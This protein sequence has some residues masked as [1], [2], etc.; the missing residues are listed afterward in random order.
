MKETTM[1][2]AYLLYD[3]FTAL[4][5]IGPHDVLN[6]VPGN[7][8]IFVAEKPGRIRN[9]SDTLSLVADASL[10]EVQSPDI[11]VVPGGFGNRT[12]LEHEPLHE[13]IRTV[14]ETSTW[15]TSVCT[16][17]LLLA[18]SGLLDG[19]PATTHWL[20]RDLLAELGAKPVPERVV[21]HGKIVTAAGVSSG[22]DMALRLVQQINGDEVAQAVQL[23]IEYDPAP[24]LDAG[25]PEKAPQPIVDLVTAVFQAQDETIRT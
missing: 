11:I 9:E 13:W 19:V 16:G 15:T 14:H 7:E 1:Q 23:G 24:P 25:S 5:I 18:A 4:D 21:Q 8:S 17:S 20:A 10:A 6:S 3:R 12:L 22:I 2:I